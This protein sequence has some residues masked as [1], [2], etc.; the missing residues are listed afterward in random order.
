VRLQALVATAFANWRTSANVDVWQ[1][2][3]QTMDKGALGTLQLLQLLVLV[4]QQLQGAP[5][6]QRAAFLGSPAGTIL[7]H[8]LSG[9]SSPDAQHIFGCE[10]LVQDVPL[11]ATAAAAAD[12]HNCVPRGHDL[13]EMLLLPGLLLAPVCSAEAAAA[14]ASSPGLVMCMHGEWTNTNCFTNVRI[15]QQLSPSAAT[16]RR[17]CL[18]AGQFAEAAPK[19]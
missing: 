8:V 13:V 2:I 7:L 5:P 4:V 17:A 9:I 1:L 15:L 12:W 16:C 19:C 3:I 6:Q 18:R 11:T 10:L 14:P